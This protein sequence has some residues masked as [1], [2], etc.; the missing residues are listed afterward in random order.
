MEIAADT[1]LLDDLP[2]RKVARRLGLHVVGSAGVLL[3][4][5]ENGVIDVVTPHFN[6]MR[7]NGLYVSNDLYEHVLRTAGED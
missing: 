2:A 4:A 5:K 6:T 7:A 3:M 1:I